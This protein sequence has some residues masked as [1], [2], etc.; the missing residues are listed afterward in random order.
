LPPGENVTVAMENARVAET[1]KSANYPDTIS[2]VGFFK[3]QI[4][5]KYNVTSGPFSNY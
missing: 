1:L 3:D 5:N 4:G 2:L